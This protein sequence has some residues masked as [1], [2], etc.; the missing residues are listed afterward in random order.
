MRVVIGFTLIAF[1]IVY[2]RWPTVLRRGLWLKTSLAIRLLSEESYKKYMVGLGWLSIVVGCVLVLFGAFASSSQ[3][4]NAESESVVRPPP[5][6]AQKGCDL[7]RGK[8]SGNDPTVSVDAR[9]CTDPAGHVEGLVQ[10]SSLRSGYNVREVAGIR[11]AHGDFSLY[12]TGFR[13]YRPQSSWTFCL[14]DRY[15]L[16]P[17]GPDR[18]SG[19]YV[20][21]ACLDN[22]QIELSRVVA[23]EQ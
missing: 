7:W 15:I 9:L 14:I 5:L 4:S 13:E 22:A 16:N 17:Q 18:L 23:S 2:V 21:H 11:D 19:N 20:S 12:D 6:E 8:F 1:G 3:G 10:W